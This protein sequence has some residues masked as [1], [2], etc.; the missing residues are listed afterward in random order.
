MHSYAVLTSGSTVILLSPKGEVIRMEE[1]REKARYVKI[2]LKGRYFV[3]LTESYIHIF[4]SD[5]GG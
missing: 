1:L 4:G 3:A 5:I 2:S